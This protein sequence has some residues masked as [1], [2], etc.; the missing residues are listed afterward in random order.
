MAN[1]S[2]IVFF[3]VC[4]AG[5]FFLALW[6]VAAVQD[7]SIFCRVLT[8]SFSRPGTKEFDY[9]WKWKEIVSASN[10]SMSPEKK[11]L[12]SNTTLW[13]CLYF[14]E[15][16]KDSTWIHSSNSRIDITK[17]MKHK[18]KI[19]LTVLKTTFK[20]F[21][22]TEYWTQKVHGKLSPLLLNF[23]KGLKIQL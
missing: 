3:C 22:S 2:P 11:K 1:W 7:V 20:K 10:D 13:V 14:S 21:T 6:P 18:F 15:R 23:Q 5:V 9:E 16:P 8:A 12:Q 17:T 4:E 19:M